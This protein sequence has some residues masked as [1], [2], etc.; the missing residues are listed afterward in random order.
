M[1]PANHDYHVAPK[2]TPD[3]K[4]FFD[5]ALA[6]N[7]PISLWGKPFAVRTGGKPIHKKVSP[8]APVPAEE[9]LPEPV[10]I[11]TE[12]N[13]PPKVQCWFVDDICIPVRDDGT[14]DF[15][16]LPPV[17][18]HRPQLSVV[19]NNEQLRHLLIMFD[20][21]CT[22]IWEFFKKSVPRQV[23]SPRLVISFAR[24]MERVIGVYMPRAV[25]HV[26]KAYWWWLEQNFDEI[27]TAVKD[28][29]IGVQINDK[30]YR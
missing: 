25:F 12:E 10:L 24:L 18:I 4:F 29:H 9:L 13:I 23:Y 1:L 8:Q 27:Q 21:R 22:R 26:N 14:L 7:V 2:I 17:N 15:S 5:L 20:V 11:Y 6:R 3:G 16:A 28:H 19:Q 30:V